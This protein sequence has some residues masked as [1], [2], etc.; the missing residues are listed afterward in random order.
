MFFIMPSFKPKT[1]KHIRLNK[2][3][4]ITLDTKHKEFLNDFSKDENNLIPELKLERYNIK[5]ELENNKNISLDQHL[6]LKDKIIELTEKI[7][8]IKNKKKEYFLDN[9]KFI[10]EYF[11]NKK[12]I[13]LGNQS[14][15]SKFFF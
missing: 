10:F 9:S 6:D 1:N 11:E 3:T 4:I 7:K 13:S 2:K 14:Q 8:E 15:I 5:Q 12:N